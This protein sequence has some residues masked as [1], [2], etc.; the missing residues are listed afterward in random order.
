MWA[1]GI[2]FR[3]ISLMYIYII[4]EYIRHIM[5]DNVFF[6]Q[7]FLTRNNIIIIIHFGGRIYFYTREERAFLTVRRNKEKT[8]THGTL[9]CSKVMENDREKPLR[10]PTRSLISENLSS[11]GPRVIRLIY[12]KEISR[13][14]G[15]QSLTY[16]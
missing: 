6:S 8:T 5:W 1:R 13:N 9:P 11:C 14:R 15:F 2:F 12:L 16:Y 10:R 4:H 7:F 3:S